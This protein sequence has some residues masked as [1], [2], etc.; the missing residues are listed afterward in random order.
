MTK[1]K[2]LHRRWRED[3]EYRSAY[4]ALDQEFGRAKA[5]IEARTQT[6]ISET[7]ARRAREPENG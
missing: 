1:L 7:Q 4:E 6:D 3:A 2:D 5:L